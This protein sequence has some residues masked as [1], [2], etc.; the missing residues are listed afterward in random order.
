MK[1]HLRKGSFGS[2]RANARRTEAGFTLIELLVVI[3]IVAALASLI[4]MIAQRATERADVANETSNLR[5]VGVVLNSVV[6]DLGRYPVGWDGIEQVSWADYVVD[7]V[8]GETSAIT[9]APILWSP[10][11][12]EN[13]PE[14]LESP[15]I[16]HFGGN[17]AI[18]PETQAVDDQQGGDTSVFVRQANLQRA[19]EQILMGSATAISANAQY[20]R[21]SPVMSDLVRVLGDPD[22]LRRENARV[23]LRFPAGLNDR[24]QYGA[25]PDF[26]R[27]GNGKALFLFGDGHVQALGP[28]ELRE[29][30]FAITY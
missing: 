26:Y 10:L 3:V 15:A 28:G 7:E 19:S 21:A 13:I 6:S 22:S 9:Q 25:Q 1:N 30:H 23:Q 12:A 14:A 18:F 11:M 29:S 16:T 27:I 20:K 17:P 4:F 8:T 5:Q 24:E 2:C